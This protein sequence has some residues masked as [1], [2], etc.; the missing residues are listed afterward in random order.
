M[1]YCFAV[2]LLISSCCSTALA[3]QNPSSAS[4]KITERDFELPQSPLLKGN[5]GAVIISDIG[6]VGFAGN[7]KNGRWI[8]Y[9]YSKKIRIKI[10]DKTAFGLAGV[11]IALRG[12]GE[13]QDKLE[14]LKAHTY[15]L[16]NGQIR[17]TEL[18]EQDVFE[19]RE[20]KWLIHKKFTLP[21]VK[22]GSLIEYSYTISS[23]YYGNLPVWY[24]QHIGYPCLY[25]SVEAIIPDMLTYL[26]VHK[27]IDTVSSY[28]QKEERQYFQIAELTVVSEGRKHKWEM[29]DIPAFGENTFVHAPQDYM[30]KIEFYLVRGY[31]NSSDGKTSISWNSA[32]TEL[33]YDRYFGVAIDVEKSAN[34]YNTM[35]KIAGA[36]N[37]LMSVSK[38]MYAYVR[39]NFHCT[40]SGD[41]YT[42]EDL[43]DVNK[44][45]QGTVAELN[46]LLVALLRQ[47]GLKADP[48]ILSTRE[49]GSHP[50]GYPVL[51][52][53]NYVICRL[54]LYGDDIYLDASVPALGFGKLPLNCYN[55][56][57]RVISDIDTGN[58]FFLPESLKELKNTSVFIQND[59]GGKTMSGSYQ[60]V[61]GYHQSYEIKAEAHKNGAAEY[62]KKINPP[63]G[64]DIVN[65]TAGI[66]SLL[67][68]DEPV[69]IHYN[70]RLGLTNSAPEIIYFTPLMAE[71]RRENPFAAADRKYPVELPVPI[72]ELYVLNMEIPNGYRIEEL[73]RSAKVAFNG[74]EGFYE[75][76]IQKDENGLQLRSR[77]KL[78]RAA[79]RADEYNTLR[80]F[81]AFV[82]KKQAEQIVF[83]KK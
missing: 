37:D 16:E 23:Y 61:P 1:R 81:F 32:N 45:R 14:N 6:T 15:N 52:K 30:D 10:I 60:S 25:S 42:G 47:K 49:Y 53:L 34:L 26:L 51:A 77:I 11:K 46:L 62:F 22:E 2:I 31:N 72:D 38:K 24:F 4:Y 65:E 40:G 44:N 82:V 56:H 35:E 63:E 55:G 79:Y 20:T 43:Y 48:V 39:D 68:P 8:S 54:K 83:K 57:A 19:D 5:P 69:K 41:I 67:R 58:V 73:P 27:G 78:N 66:D 76:I 74:D 70:F 29:K 18:N 50:T 80:D 7:K 9:V 64:I 33:R 28:T 12:Q 21:D 59:E 71:A 17:E 75:Y 36:D 3:Q 13:F